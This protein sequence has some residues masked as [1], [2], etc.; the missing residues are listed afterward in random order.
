MCNIYLNIK[1]KMPS[2]FK[3][4]AAQCFLLGSITPRP[5]EHL[6]RDTPAF[7]GPLAVFV[8]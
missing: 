2:P 3:R 6:C 8:H 7:M 4:P 1:K 5:T